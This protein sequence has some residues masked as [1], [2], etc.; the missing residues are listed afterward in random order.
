M[1]EKQACPT[2]GKRV[3]VLASHM[4]LAHG[5]EETM[6]QSQI[7]KLESLAGK[8]GIDGKKLIEEL[9]QAVIN[10]LPPSPEKIDW[11]KVT[12]DISQEVEARIAAKLDHTLEAIAQSNNNP[13]QSE[14][15]IKGVV[16]LLRPEL[17]AAADKAVA[18]HSRGL[19]EQIEAKY[20]AARAAQLGGDGA[21]SGSAN[22]V[23]NTPIKDFFSQLMANLPQLADAYA[24]I[25]Q[26][27]QP[28]TLAGF[29]Q[30]QTAFKLADSINRLQ[31][32]E[33]TIEQLGKEIAETK[34]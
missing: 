25:K 26:A 14:G 1:K 7:E 11:Q 21:G 18:A 5:K 3:K 27:G 33:A 10:R 12:E 34:P 22:G 31:K 17:N 23:G 28:P 9:S 16:E 32:G 19:R 4:R 8:V 29:Q 20:A 30:L 15:V 2:C 13:Q 6:A 24:K